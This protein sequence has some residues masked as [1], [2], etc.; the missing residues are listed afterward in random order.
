MPKIV[1]LVKQT[2]DVDAIRID[3]KTGQPDLAGVG[4]K[5][6][7]YDKN[8]V[9][10]GVQ[11]KEKNAGS[12]VVILSLGGPKLEES[13]K[14]ALAMGGDEAILLRDPAFEKVDTAEKSR[15]LAAAI[16]KIGGVDLVLAAEE[17][18][19]S[20]SAQTGP[21]VA[22]HLGW[23]LVSYA[24][25]LKLEGT[26]LT[27]DREVDEG[28][29]SVRSPLPAVVTVLESLNEPRL[30]ALM[31]ILQAKNKPMKV[32]S[33]AELGAGPVAPKVE[34]VRNVAPKMERKQEIVPGESPEAQAAELAKRLAK[35]GVIG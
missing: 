16:Q 33:A 17:S 7:D 13:V 10:A 30:P 14:E 12:R 2:P 5:V 8:A 26:T 29:E 25:E 28:I 22:E 20:H 34:R 6:S 31:Q 32:L 27:A 15:L 24:T 4:V 18:A 9:E 19:D 35:A 1:V 11:I 23:P 21:R 3:P